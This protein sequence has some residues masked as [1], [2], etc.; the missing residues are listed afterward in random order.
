[1]EK[2]LRRSKKCSV[3]NT[4]YLKGKTECRK[5]NYDFTTEYTEFPSLN[6][7]TDQDIDKYTKKNKDYYSSYIVKNSNLVNNQISVDTKSGL[8]DMNLDLYRLKSDKFE[9]TQRVYFT[10]GVFLY[11]VM[12]VLQCLYVFNHNNNLVTSIFYSILG[13]ISLFGIVLVNLDNTVYDISFSFFDNFF[14]FINLNIWILIICV[15]TFYTIIRNELMLLT[16]FSIT[17]TNLIVYLNL[18]ILSYG[19]VSYLGFSKLLKFIQFF[20]YIIILAVAYFNVFY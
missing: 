20:V 15:F 4:D 7:L 2:I 12:V 3:C 19:I 5:C 1:M 17:D 9:L 14:E 13:I 8:L 11:L 6:I 16:G 18:F 10:I